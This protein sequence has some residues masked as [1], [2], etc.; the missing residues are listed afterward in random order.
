[1]T[2]LTLPRVGISFLSADGQVS[3]EWR[4]FLFDL[5]QRAGGVTG[6][7]TEDLTL[8]QFEDA[9]IEETKWALGNLAQQFGQ[10]PV[11]PDP[12]APDPVP[13]VSELRAEVEELRRKVEALQQG[14]TA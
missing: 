3:P 2:M 11:V 13:E 5:S 8:S 6:S 7:S 9:G 4:R 10:L 1:M 14:L 12:L